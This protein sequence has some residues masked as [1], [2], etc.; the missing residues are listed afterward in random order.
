MDQ[1]STAALHFISVK[2]AADISHVARE[3]YGSINVEEEKLSF[4]R[5]KG[6]GANTAICCHSEMY[7]DHLTWGC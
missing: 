4:H 7:I 2:A 3:K 6:R 5:E 1:Y